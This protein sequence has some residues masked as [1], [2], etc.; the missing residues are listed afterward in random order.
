MEFKINKQKDKNSINIVYKDIE[1]PRFEIILGEDKEPE[2]FLVLKKVD[3]KNLGLREKI[4][5]IRNIIR[6]AKTHKI[7][8]INIK[9]EDI[10]VLSE[11]IEF[12]VANFLM[13]NYEFNKFKNLQN[14][15]YSGVEEV[16]FIV[17]ENKK[18]IFDEEIKLGKILG[19]NINK[20]RDLSNSPANI[21]NPITLAEYA[22]KQAKY[23]KGVSLKILEKK[24]LQKIKAG[25][26]L[27]VASG[28]QHEPRLIVLEYFGQ[29]KNERPV[30]LIGKGVTHDNGGINLKPSSGGSL[31]EMH[32][33]MSG[34]SSVL[35]AFFALVE[36][37]VKKNIVVIVP[38]VENSVSGKSYRPGDIIT[39]LSGKTIEVL[40]TDAEGRIILADALTYVQNTFQTKAI[41][42][43][44]TLTGAALVAL[45]T[46]ASA[47]MSNDE[48][49]TRKIL[50]IGN[51][52]TG[53]FV[54][55]LP[56]W[57]DYKSA[58]KNKRADIGNI[59][60]SNSRFGGSINGG[61]FLKEFILE[62]SKWL[63]IDMAPRM[64]STS[65][66]NLAPGA[67][68]ETVRL[69]VEFVKSF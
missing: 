45:G 49:L 8:K 3:T 25:G 42:D 18:N 5:N 56:L 23:L 16:N 65:S 29:S 20:A 6:L 51:N 47:I 63:H 36:M 50:D 68:G 17:S 60:E 35:H 15:D 14:I 48:S 53:D 66:D 67:M 12:I 40:N 43:V 21:L 2:E 33:D 22:K 37:K 1:T 7:K 10:F 52:I 55:E 11:S 41:L 38:A 30:V 58:I 54:W 26:I 69:L 57:E 46:S 64:T 59:P 31:E 61:M 32:M 44:G 9:L 28:S 62:N 39:S 34:A 19:K 24:E 27:A 13:A 4:Y